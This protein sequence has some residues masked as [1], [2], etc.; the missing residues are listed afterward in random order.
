MPDGRITYFRFNED[1]LLKYAA[2]RSTYDKYVEKKCDDFIE[3]AKRVFAL[4]SKGQSD[5]RSS[6][7]YIESFKSHKIGLTWVVINND[8]QAAWVEFGAHA[9]GKT[10]VLKYRPMGI[11]M[12]ILAAKE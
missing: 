1:L 4:R 6:Q 3:E 2:T 12:D 9:G 11:A 8:D 10:L 5:P 7:R